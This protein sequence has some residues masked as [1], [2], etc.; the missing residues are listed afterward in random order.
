[1]R[2]RIASLLLLA[3]FTS[4]IS[5]EVGERYR[6]YLKKHP[7]NT[8]SLPKDESGLYRIKHVN[9]AVNVMVTILDGVICEERH[10]PVDR[11]DADAILN[12]HRGGPFILE[13]QGVDEVRWR[14]E[15]KVLSARFSKKGRYLQISNASQVESHLEEYRRAKFIKPVAR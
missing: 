2:T 8:E 5:A 6:D 14:S 15:D 12:A 11:G 1:M 4:R 7:T 10:Y 13:V 9:G 3:A